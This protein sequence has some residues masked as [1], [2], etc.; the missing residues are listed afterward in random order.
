MT[1]E[2]YAQEL[3]DLRGSVVA[4]ASMTNKAIDNAVT[5][6]AQR[7]VRLAEQVIASDRAINEHRWRTEEQALLVIATQAP[8]ARDLRMIAA[9]IHIVTDLERMADHAAGIAKIALQTAD[10]PPLKPL[11]DIPRMSEIART[12]LHDAIT[13]FIEDDQASARAIVAR[14]DEVDALYEQIYRELLTFMLAD[15]TTIDQATHLLWAAHNLE[16]IADRVTNICERVVF[17]ATGQLE[18]LAVS[19]Y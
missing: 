16:R 11:V 15:P 10:Q 5:A 7:D 18:E 12:M 3:A 17:A 14:D 13:A 4:M 2:H 6:L 8:M 1:R 19:T 9:V